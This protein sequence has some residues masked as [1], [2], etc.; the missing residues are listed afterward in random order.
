MRYLEC[1][2]I[3]LVTF[4]ARLRV[5]E[6]STHF[7]LKCITLGLTLNPKHGA[8]G[9]WLS[10]CITVA[11][12]GACVADSRCGCRRRAAHRG[13]AFFGPGGFT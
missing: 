4:T 3:R 7:A 2:I 1:R 5:Y 10:I 13:A 11:T 12:H 6:Y 8:L 9:L